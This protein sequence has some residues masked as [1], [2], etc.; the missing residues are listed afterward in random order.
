MI[1][2]SPRLDPQGHVARIVLLRTSA[3]YFFKLILALTGAMSNTSPVLC[4]VLRRK[5]FTGGDFRMQG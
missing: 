5:K 1:Y 4:I 3:G 2:E